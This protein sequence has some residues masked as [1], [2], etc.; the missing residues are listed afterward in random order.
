MTKK[1]NTCYCV[2]LDG[3]IFCDSVCLSCSCGNFWKPWPRHFIFGL[4]V[5]P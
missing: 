1:N 4:Q 2:V 5:H 3:R